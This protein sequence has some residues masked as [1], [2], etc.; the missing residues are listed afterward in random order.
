MPRLTPLTPDT[1]V[2]ASRD[3]LAGAFNL[4]AGLTPG[5]E[6]SDTGA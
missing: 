4:L 3:L 1:A 6:G 2:G 5:S